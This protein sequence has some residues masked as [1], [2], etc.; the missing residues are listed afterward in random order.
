[1]KQQAITSSTGDLKQIARALIVRYYLHNMSLSPFIIFCHRCA[2][3]CIVP[4]NQK[5]HHPSNWI[6]RHAMYVVL[7]FGLQCVTQ[8]QP[9]VLFCCMTSCL[10][11]QIIV[12]GI[13][14]GPVSDWIEHA[15]STP[16]EQPRNK[17]LERISLVTKRMSVDWISSVI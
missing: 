3:C 2:N 4:F 17:S 8:T 6:L 1:M 14:A 12:L 9:R 13:N 5:H 15:M 11:I 7:H 16:S 10:G